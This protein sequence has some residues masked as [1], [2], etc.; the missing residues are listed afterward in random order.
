MLSPAVCEPSFPLIW[1]ALR[2][3]QHLPSSVWMCGFTRLLFKFTVT[4]S[5][6]WRLNTNYMSLGRNG[7]K[8]PTAYGHKDVIIAYTL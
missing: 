4:S 6:F 1:Y 3:T 5:Y 2:L 7:C 8:I